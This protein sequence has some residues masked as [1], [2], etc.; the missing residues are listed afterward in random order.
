MAAE[1]AKPPAKTRTRGIWPL[2]VQTFEDWKEDQATR[3]AAALSFYSALSI[4]PL[5]VIAI[6]ISGLA[7]G[8]EAAR[9]EILAEVQSV[10]GAESARTVD[11][12]IKGANKPHSGIVATVLG[13]A[14]LL[15]GAS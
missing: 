11:S 8:Q 2:L 12:M 14:V 5:L 7:L 3:L 13:V 6:A 10:I 1:R 15:F 4:A 9:G